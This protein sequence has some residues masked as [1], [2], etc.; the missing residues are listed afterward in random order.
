MG[1]APKLLISP[2]V[3]E[4]SG[5]TEGGAS[6][7]LFTIIRIARALKKGAE[8]PFPQVTVHPFTNASSSS[9]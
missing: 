9:V 4:M 5:R 1:E 8:A 2:Q 3:G 6:R 7:Q